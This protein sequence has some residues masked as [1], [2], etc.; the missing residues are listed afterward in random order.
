MEGVGATALMTAAARAIETERDDGRAMLSDPL[1]RP[2]AGE[3]GFALLAQLE[4]PT[5]D[6]GAPVFV[7]RH[8]FI[9]DVL[10][11]LTAG[12]GIRQIVLVAAGLDTRAFRLDWPAGTRLF[13]VDQ[14][15]VLAYKNEVLAARGARPRCERVE[16]PADLREDWP[17]ALEHCGFDPA[18]PTAWVAEGILF[19]IREASV[20]RLLDEM[21][22]LSAA[23]SC[24]V[25][26]VLGT[27][28]GPRE[29]TKAVFAGWDAP[30]VFFSDDPAALVGGHGWEPEV[31]AMDEVGRRLGVGFP[32]VGQL[33][34]ARC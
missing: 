17:R 18:R 3:K 32:P 34:I 4:V 19:Y 9:D 12:A 28:R 23:G 33:V 7:V 16:V 21:R 27:E 10:A 13:E 31:V 20:H 25:A 2:L 30:F 26:D 8:R 24:L 5:S 1:A 15:H 29:D 14:Q 11:D 22:R 6:D